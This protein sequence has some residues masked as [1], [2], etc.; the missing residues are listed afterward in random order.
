MKA[1]SGEQHGGEVS[2]GGGVFVCGGDIAAEVSRE[3]SSNIHCQLPGS[4][5]M[6]QLA[7]SLSLS[8]SSECTSRCWGRD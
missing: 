6:Q 2:D 8:Y 5:E 4:E 7:C 3:Y 1:R